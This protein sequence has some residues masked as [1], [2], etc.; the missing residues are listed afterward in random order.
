MPTRKTP[1]QIA[2]IQKDIEDADN[3]PTVEELQQNAVEKLGH[4][5]NWEFLIEPP[6]TEAV[7]QLLS[8][9]PP[10]HGV[11]H[12]DFADFVQPLPQKKKIKK[13]HPTNPNLM[14]D[15]NVDCWVLYMSVAGRQ[16]MLNA[17]AEKNAWRVEIE[18]EPNSPV[19]APGFLSLEQ[20]IIY[21]EYIKIW[22][23]IPQTVTGTATGDGGM[24]YPPSELFLGSRN[25]Q[26]WVPF[27]G[28]GQAAGTNPYEKVETSARGRALGAWGFGV[29]PGSGI[30]S[31]EEMQG[32]AENRQ[33]MEQEQRNLPGP[34]EN[35]RRPNREQLEE[36]ALTVI[37][38]LRQV[39]GASEGENWAKVGQYVTK[40]LGAVHA[41]DADRNLLHL[42]G[43]KDG[44]L[45]MMTKFLQ[46]KVVQIQ[47]ELI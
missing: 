31:L 2:Q 45:M 10:V 32:I 4:I 36:Q 8:T 17:A 18:P 24:I 39:T 12:I 3:L 26:A 19:G 42:E 34:Q 40:S 25:G 27:S 22:V 6:T 14:I 23:R 29:F 15:E 21:R 13:Q 7:L 46:E 38:Q 30:A 47:S 11:E 41:Y 1:E 33:G 5:S 9:L 43:L 20:R 35:T 44:Q 37:E 28:G 16:A